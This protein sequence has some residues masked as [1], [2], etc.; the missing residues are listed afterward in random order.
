M[1][2][3]RFFDCSSDRSR[4]KVIF[5]TMS[6]IF[7]L[8]ILAFAFPV[9]AQPVTIEYIAHASFRVT[10]P[11]GKQVILDP[12]ASKVW[13]GYAFPKNMD[14]DALVITHPHYD[15]DGGQYRNLPLAW[16]TLP[17]QYRQPG[18][19]EL[20]DMVLRGVRAKHADPY[21]KEF[22]QINT[23]WIVEVAGLRIAHLGDNGPLTDT[24]AQ[25]IGEVDIL[26]LPAD[27]D[28]HILK[29]AESL[30][31]LNALKPRIQIPMH[32]CHP[33]LQ[34]DG[35]CPGGLLPVA[36]PL[37]PD[38]KVRTLQGYRATLS[39]E[40]LPQQIEYWIFQPSPLV[41]RD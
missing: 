12:Y 2:I 3:A 27:K 29:D 32:Y 11:E 24:V 23:I 38:T 28:Q 8:A 39:A 36:E 30:A 33:E 9:F 16:D 22:G 18:R 26:M 6:A 17:A 31:F 19:Y 10:S 37:T 21:G 35:E 20:G 4:L 13:I 25:E 7:G 15:H 14:A 5:R 40:E 1:R 41:S 34:P